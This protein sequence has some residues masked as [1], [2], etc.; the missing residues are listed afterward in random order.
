MNN[1]PKLKIGLLMDSFDVP[2]W[3]YKMIEKIQDS[4]HSQISLII[5]NQTEILINISD[6]FSDE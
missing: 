5:M 2:Y 3:I 4:T 6:D 1:M